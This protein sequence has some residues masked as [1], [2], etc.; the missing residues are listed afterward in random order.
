VA[1]NYLAKC[2]N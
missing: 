1:S 2:L